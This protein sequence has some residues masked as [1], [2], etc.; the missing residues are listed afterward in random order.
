MSKTRPL[1]M[2]TPMVQAILEG[3]KKETRRIAKPEI[4]HILT[5]G[6]QEERDI[7]LE[8]CPYGV[9]GDQFWVRE[10]WKLS[11]LNQHAGPRL[12]L[13]TD[14]KAGGAGVNFELTEDKDREQ[15]YRAL[16]HGDAWRPGIHMPRW[17]S[18]LTLQLTEVRAERLKFINQTGVRA[19]GL[20]ECTKDGYLFKWGWEGLP[21]KEWY[22][23]GPVEAFAGLWD[24]L[25]KDRGYPWESNPWVWVLCFKEVS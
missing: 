5:R 16:K 22:P 3:R 10:T 24:S 14:Y 12:A 6:N 23:G 17:A 18:R 2:S 4:S 1:L 20:Q 11:V 13:T 7:I 19:E 21:W 8:D 25:N 15:A 9:A